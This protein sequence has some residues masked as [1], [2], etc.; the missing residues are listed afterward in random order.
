MLGVLGAQGRWLAGGRFCILISNKQ[1]MLHGLWRHPSWTYVGPQPGT[2]LPPLAQLSPTHCHMRPKAATDPSFPI[3]P[4]HIA[5][6]RS[7]VHGEVGKRV[8]VRVAQ[9][10][11]CKHGM[12]GLQWQRQENMMLKVQGQRKALWPTSW[13]PNCATDQA[14]THRMHTAHTQHAYAH[15]MHMHITHLQHVRSVRAAVVGVGIVIPVL[16]CPQVPSKR[17]WVD[18]EPGG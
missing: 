7:Y 4:C 5:S 16:Y 11:Q 14:G 8:R 17:D 12:E 10:S 1:G 13:Y 3:I 9:A 18:A 2:L 6:H 15:A